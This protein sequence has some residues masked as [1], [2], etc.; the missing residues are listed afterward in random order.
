MSVSTLATPLRITSGLALVNPKFRPQ[1]SIDGRYVVRFAGTDQEVDAALR[2]RYEVFTLELGRGLASSFPTGRDRDDY[3]LT[4]QH[5]ILI[6]RLQ[7]QVVGTCRLRTYEIARTVQSF[8]C[9]REFDL[10]S[11]PPEVLAGTLEVGRICL[12]KAQRNSRAHQFLR[13]GL[14]LGLRQKDKRYVLGS[15]PLATQDPM[16]AGRVFDQLSNE[17]YLHPE[18]RVR[19]RTGFKCLWY[20]MPEGRQ[21]DLR[22]SSMV[23]MCLRVGARL[24]GPPAINR[25]LRTIDLPM[26]LNVEEMGQHTNRLWW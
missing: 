1:E 18:F 11:L 8:C 26:L 14:A 17:G 24:C 13:R 15:L 9:S 22:L 25:Q 21:C 4:S 3:D 20:R 16:E 7:R 23:R 6:D 10:T 19:P 2:L 5:V 12:A